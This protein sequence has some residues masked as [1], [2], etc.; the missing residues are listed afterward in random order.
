MKKLRIVLCLC[1]L[2]FALFAVSCGNPDHDDA[3]PQTETTDIAG[4][5]TDDEP[6]I[7]DIS[8]P[9][10]PEVNEPSDETDSTQQN[11]EPTTPTTPT[12]PDTTE[13][14]N[15]TTT[16][17]APDEPET[18]P[19]STEPE[20]IVP[21]IPIEPPVPGTDPSEDVHTHSLEHNASKRATCTENGNNEYWHCAL[22]GN[23][24]ADADAK[25][26]IDNIEI[27]A[28]GH[29]Y[30]VTVIDPTCTADGYTQNKCK[31]CGDEY[32]TDTV[33]SC[34]HSYGE[35]ITVKRPTCTQSGLQK[36]ICDVCGDEEETV[37]PPLGHEYD[38]TVAEPTCT[39]N[40]Y[41]V[42]TCDNCGDRYTDSETPSK[43]HS[44]GESITV[45]QP[46]CTQ[47]GLQKKIC[48]VCGDEEET[49]LPPLGH[50]Y[51]T[52]VAEPTCTE[53]GYTVHTCKNCGDTFMDNETPSKGHRYNSEWSYDEQS[54]W[55]EA[56]CGCEI[57]PAKEVH[58][59]DD[60]GACECGYIEAW[61]YKLIFT[62]DGDGYTVS[63]IN[64]NDKIAQGSL[65]VIIPSEYSG[66]AVTKI[67][68]NAFCDNDYIKSVYI[69]KTVIAIGKSAFEG[70][71]IT[72]ATFETKTGWKCSKYENGRGATSLMLGT[73]SN[74]AK[75]LKNTRTRAGY[76]EYYWFR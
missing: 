47:S 42:H 73:A 74:A 62:A 19:V 31:L 45:K 49:I 44:Y 51:D 2:A 35:S 63:G 57:E 75:L 67:A 14:P 1:I 72:A 10:T 33:A 40:G 70:S 46:T 71:A 18:P 41:T 39:E 37:L 52:T 50:E 25:N 8:K 15:T 3:P 59:Y 36:K 60:V 69:P 65:D 24:F 17:T 9:V 54:H 16:P 21:N 13:I 4:P 34:G 32:V 68:D 20:P 22:C 55:H 66:K 56:I 5:T 43:G 23:D 11:N 6:V 61:D 48:D 28:T 29:E 38:T 7:S 30:I 27:A 12:A 76:A 58:V 64:V 26:V 53:N